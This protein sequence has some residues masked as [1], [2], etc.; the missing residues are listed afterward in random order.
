MFLT[1]SCI[2]ILGVWVVTRSRMNLE[3]GV[4]TPEEELLRTENRTKARIVAKKA[5]SLE[6]KGESTT[7]ETNGT[8]EVWLT[9]GDGIYDTVAISVYEKKEPN[10]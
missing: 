2:V 7:Y 3:T 5:V 10:S 8:D 9:D 4:S 1:V 6:P